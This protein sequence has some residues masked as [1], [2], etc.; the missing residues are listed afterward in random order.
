MRSSTSISRNSSVFA[1]GSGAD[2]P[3][4]IIETIQGDNCV[5][6]RYASGKLVTKYDSGTIKEKSADSKTEITRYIN[7]DV[8]Q[9]LPDGKVRQNF[10][11]FRYSNIVKIVYFYGSNGATSTKYPDGIE[12][13]EFPTGQKEINHLDGRK[14]IEFP[15]GLKEV[16]HKNGKRETFYP[17]GSQKVLQPNGDE[18]IY[19]KDGQKVRNPPTVNYGQ[20][21]WVG[22]TV[23][24]GNPNKR[25][26]PT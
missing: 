21:K 1:P 9:H 7:G 17:N 10:M 3:A 24:L 8:Q 15:D 2:I 13:L 26:S 12:I 20:S 11:V 16:T 5:T 23:F 19:F 4:G 18:I 14:E 6:H 22:V 25:I